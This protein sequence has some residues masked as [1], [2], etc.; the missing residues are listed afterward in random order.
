MKHL[1]VVG[2]GKFFNCSNCGMHFTTSVLFT[3]Q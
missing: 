1:T 2:A 3:E